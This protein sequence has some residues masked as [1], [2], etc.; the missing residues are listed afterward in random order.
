VNRRTLL[1]TAAGLVLAAGAGEL[2]LPERRVWALD[3]SMVG[4]SRYTR[5][6]H[7]GGWHTTGIWIDGRYYPVDMMPFNEVDWNK[8]RYSVMGYLVD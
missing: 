3:A 8:V 6:W 4:D 5:V 1:R 7:G 2:V